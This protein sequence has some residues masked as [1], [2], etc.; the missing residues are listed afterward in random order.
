MAITIWP[1]LVASVV[2]LVPFTIFS[3]LLVPIAE[4]VASDVAVVGSLRGLGGIAALAVGVLVAPLL[5]R[6]PR[7]YA[8]AL[9]LTVLA[10]SS[11]VATLGTLSALIVFCLL[12]GAGTALL[13]PAL[14]AAAADHFTTGAE[15]G[16]AAT[17]VTATTSL[18]ALLA[19]PLVAWPAEFWGWRGDYVA[20]AVVSA[21]LAVELVRRSRATTIDEVKPRVG[22]LDAFRI[23]VRI[24][25][26]L[27]LTAMAFLRTTAFMGYLSYLA[28]LFDFRFHLAP[29]VFAFV[30][31]LSG[32]SFF[33]ANFAT[34]RW[35]ATHGD[36]GVLALAAGLSSGTLAMLVV[37]LVPDLVVVL[38][39]TA[40]LGAT[41]ATIAAGVTTMLVHRAGATRGTVLSLQA[42]AT[43]LGVFMGSAVGGLGLSLGGFPGLGVALAAVTALGLPLCLCVRQPR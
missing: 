3:T 19:A 33:V 26:A 16:R 15:A 17:L 31:T 7:G 27:P 43:S 22:Y 9:A 41:H 4:Q 30:W 13:T 29:T 36:R 32:A 40:I 10:A 11:L 34:G 18:T 14:M 39:G 23:A 21:V 24:P 6:V 8:A 37:H 20:V 38:A 2:G 1:T 5:D 35:L 42:A 12:T 28:A 25:G